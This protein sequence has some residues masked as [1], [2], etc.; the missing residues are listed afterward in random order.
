ML[1]LNN[2]LEDLGFTH[3][4]CMVS[5]SPFCFP[6]CKASPRNK[7]ADPAKSHQLFEFP[8]DSPCGHCSVLSL[9]LFGAGTVFISH[10]HTTCAGEIQFLDQKD[11][12]KM[13][14][15]HTNI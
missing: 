15:H 13:K 5:F 6:T 7:F 1:L 8:S 4:I 10:V 14:E 2:L 12:M 11:V 3:N 9:T